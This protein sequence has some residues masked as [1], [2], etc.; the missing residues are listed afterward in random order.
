[1][2]RLGFLLAIVCWLNVR[3]PAQWTASG[4]I[5]EAHTQNHSLVVQQPALGTNIRFSDVANRGESFHPPLYYG[6]R[7]GYWFRRYWGAEIEFTHLKMF[8]KVDQPAIVT[9]ILNGVP[10][11]SLVPINTIVQRFSISHGVNLL[12]ANAVF[13]HELGRSDQERAPRAYIALRFGAGATIPH[14]E[15]TIQNVTDEHYE[16]GSPAVQLAASLEVRTWNHLYWMGEYKFTRARAEVGVNSG[17]A[18]T[19]LES[20]HLVTGPVLHF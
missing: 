6:V 19:L 15:S 16:V 13:H 10:I 2:R 4:Y 3:S 12:L 7:S 20:H 11:N 8:A 18:T 5:G 1:M 14:A 9:G 17:T